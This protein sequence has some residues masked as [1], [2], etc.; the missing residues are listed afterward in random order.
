VKAAAVK[1]LP[2]ALVGKGFLWLVA[3]LLAFLFLAQSVAA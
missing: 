2:L 1:A 3:A